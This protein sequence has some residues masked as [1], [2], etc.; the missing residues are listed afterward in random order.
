MASAMA[1]KVAA[2]ASPALKLAAFG[3]GV[4]SDASAA[5]RRSRRRRLRER[6]GS[7]LVCAQAGR[8]G[9]AGE[10]VVPVVRSSISRRQALALTTLSAVLFSS[11]QQAAQARDIPVFG[12]RKVQKQVVDEVKE[13]VKEGEAEA[14]AVSGA[15]SGVVKTAVADFSVTS[16][17]GFSPEGGLSPAYQAG[18]VAG[19]ELVAVLVASTVVNGLLSPSK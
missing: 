10:Q 3:C 6:T 9:G 2:C 8:E 1:I 11:S 12:F 7:S 18:V 13:L 5:G 15:V 19:A 4:S 16:S 17:K 14:Q